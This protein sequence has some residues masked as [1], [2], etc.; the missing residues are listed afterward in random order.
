MPEGPSEAQIKAMMALFKECGIEIKEVRIKYT[1]DV[2]GRNV[3]SCKELTRAE[4]AKVI[5]SLKKQKGG[6]N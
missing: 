2:I 1:G 3:A 5:D 6:N 4:A